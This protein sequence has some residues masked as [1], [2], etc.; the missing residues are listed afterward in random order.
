LGQTSFSPL[1]PLGLQ[2]PFSHVPSQH[3][4][5]QTTSPVSQLSATP[6]AESS[7]HPALAKRTATNAAYFKWDAFFF[8]INS[9]L[10]VSEVL[11]SL[12]DW[13]FFFNFLKRKIT[14]FERCDECY[15]CQPVSIDSKTMR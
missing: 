8:I 2:T 9:K 5:P 12:N 10:Q 4:F 6:F 11:I 7:E 1:E 3:W 14:Y 13:P 15:S